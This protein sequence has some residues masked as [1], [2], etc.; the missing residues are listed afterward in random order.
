MALKPQKALIESS[1][2]QRGRSRRKLRL[3][4]NAQASGL[5]SSAAIVHDISET[6][7][8]VEASASLAAGDVID[9]ELSHTN[10]KLAEVVWVSGHLAGCKFFENLTS[11]SISAA[12]L[13]GSF[14]SAA[15]GTRDGGE[16]VSTRADPLTPG[17]QGRLSFVTKMW[18]IVCLTSL[19]WATVIAIALWIAT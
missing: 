13:Q 7:L 11:G 8:L 12:L 6:G 18:I 14:T 1:F 5:P 9:V 16:T 3:E 15:S 10:V 4:I 2:D 17:R 19:L